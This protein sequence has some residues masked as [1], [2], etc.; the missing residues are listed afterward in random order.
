MKYFNSVKTVRKIYSLSKASWLASTKR[1]EVA[2]LSNKH[3][4]SCLVQLRLV[5]YSEHLS[6]HRDIK[7]YHE[8]NVTRSLQKGTFTNT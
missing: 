8:T 6:T 3:K 4:I 1:L 2:V 7:I 5:V